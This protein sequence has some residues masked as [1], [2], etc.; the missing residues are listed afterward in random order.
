M[1]VKYL[2]LSAAVVALSLVG[3]ISTAKSEAITNISVDKNVGNNFSVKTLKIA[4]NQ[5]LLLAQ[6]NIDELL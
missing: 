4:P 3:T 6:S 5:P 1:K 2:S